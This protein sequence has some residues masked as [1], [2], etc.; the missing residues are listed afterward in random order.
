MKAAASITHGVNGKQKAVKRE[1]EKSPQGTP[2]SKNNQGRMGSV[3]APTFVPRETGRNFGPR[4]MNGRVLP[5]PP[6]QFE[7]KWFCD[8]CQSSHGGPICHC[9]ICNGVGHM[10][11][12]CPHRDEKESRG[13]VPDKNWV[14][15]IKV[16]EIC[17]TEHA[18]PCTLGQKQNPQIQA[19][20]AT[21]QSREWSNDNNFEANSIKTRGATRYCMHC[22]YK[23]NL[24]D[25]NCPLVREKAMY[26]QCSF[27]GDVG[28]LSDN[29]AARLQALQEQ[30]KG[31]LC[32]YCGDVDHTSENCSK[33]KENIAREKADINRRNI[34]KYEASKQHT[35]KGQENTYQTQ[36][37]KTDKEGQSKQVP[38]QPPSPGGSHTHPGG[39]G[40][41]GGGGQPPRKPNGNKNLPPDKTDDEEDQ[42]EKDSDRTV[43][44][45]DS[46]SG[47]GVRIVKR[48]GTE[49]S[50]K[51]LLKLVSKTKRRRKRR[52]YRKGN[53]G[54][55]GDSSPS[56]SEGS[57]DDSDESD[58]DIGGLRG[59]RGHRGQR[60]R[61]GPVRPVGPTIHVPMPPSQPVPMTVPLKD[62]NITISNDG[63]ERSFQ[64]L[65]DS[66]TQMFTQQASLNQTLHSHLTQGIQA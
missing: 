21:K 62:A 32:S 58:L 47:E 33:V 12:S 45:S 29:C 2:S 7:K 60:G 18:G 9:P 38:T 61:I 51:Q 42:E 26:F 25:L 59:K 10:Y 52:S 30:Q 43:T 11:Y 65:S 39:M 53:G 27:C 3:H 66:L 17:G 28:H 19:M 44:V 13:V 6:Y 14:P 64:T 24:H 1:D 20:L 46:T 23:D 48:D 37:G 5:R 55:G 49:L 16:C 63:M 50:L 54:G 36:Q 8:N 22:G 41:T 35:A 15:P 56:S 57:E 31:Y 4:G 40:G 34:E